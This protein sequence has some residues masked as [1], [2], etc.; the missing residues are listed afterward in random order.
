MKQRSK[1]TGSIFQPRGSSFYWIAYMSG[2]KRHYETTK[3][4]RKQDAQDLLTKRLG[5]IARGIA[6]TPSMGRL[7]LSDGLRAVVENLEMNGRK[8]ADDTQ[9]RID[10]YLL[11]HFG[12]DRKMNGITTADIEKYKAARLADDAAAATINR[13]LAAL[14]R[15]YRLAI[16]GG[17]LHHMPYVGLLRENNARTGFFERAQFDEV[18]EHMPT[19]LHPPLWFAYITGWRFKSEVLSLTVS[20]VDLKGGFVRLEVGS[21]KS[22]EGRTFF[23][24]QKLR[25]VLTQQIASIDALKKRGII[26]PYIFHRANGKQ[27]KDLRRHWELALD[28]AGYP[29]KLLHDFRRTAVRSLERAGVPRSTAMAMVGHKTESIYRRYAIV[30]EAMH[31]EG[32]AKLDTWADTQEPSTGKVAPFKK[33]ATAK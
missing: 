28:A 33:V 16:R 17:Q 6:V 15:G 8:T 20:N 24:T 3:S 1:G 22:G 23:M 26:C 25:T 12:A 4:K 21:T 29:G 30:D 7:T 31:R 2:G 32:A 9:R 13:E 10:T 5:D 14:R 19:E 11:P 27:I 18:L